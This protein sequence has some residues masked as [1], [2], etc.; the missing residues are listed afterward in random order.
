MTMP[1]LHT[2]TNLFSNLFYLFSGER[3]ILNNTTREVKSV[4]KKYHFSEIKT[5]K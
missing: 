5:K 3:E 2:T 1:E 4:S